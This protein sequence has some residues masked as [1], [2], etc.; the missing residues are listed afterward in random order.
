MSHQIINPTGLFNSV[1]YGFSQAVVATGAR[2]VFLSGQVAVDS[3]ESLVAEDMLGQA[4]AALENI[5]L[6]LSELKENMSAVVMLRIYIRED[7]NTPESQDDISKALAQVFGRQKPASSWVIVSGLTNPRWLL[8][9]EAQAVL[10][11]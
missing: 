9:I 3:Q 1:Q 11:S 10:S 5:R 2:H 4:L 8:E 6:L 7:A